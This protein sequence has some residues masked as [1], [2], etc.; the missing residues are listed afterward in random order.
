[1]PISGGRGVE[2]FALLYAVS[3]NLSLSIKKELRC[4][5]NIF[6]FNNSYMTTKFL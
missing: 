2:W 4:T 6:V 1:M 5:L 3:E